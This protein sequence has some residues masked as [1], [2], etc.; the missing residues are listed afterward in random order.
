MRA[1]LDLCCLKRP[2]DLQDQPLVRL[3]T[4]AVLS[5]QAMAGE[6]VDLIRSDALLLENSLNPVQGRRE[7]I[8]LWLSQGAVAELPEPDLQRR[9]QELTALGFKNFDAFHVA[10]AELAGA[11]VFVTV[12]LGI[13]RVA[14]RHE[15]GINLRF[16]DPI[17]FVEE[18]SQ[19][20][21]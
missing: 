9:L 3:Q 19:W 18:L 20:K 13:L 21:P 17:Q 7:A 1:Y 8:D 16:A 14:A 10:S 6:A 15:S 5:I 2:F 4:E 12:D 11:S